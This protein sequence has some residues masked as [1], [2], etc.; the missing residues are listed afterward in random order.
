[1]TLPETKKLLVALLNKLINY[2]CVNNMAVELVVNGTTISHN[3]KFIAHYED[4]LDDIDAYSFY[5]S[6]IKN[7]NLILTEKDDGIFS[8]R[9]AISFS[10]DGDDDIKIKYTFR[11]LNYNI[12]SHEKPTTTINRIMEINNYYKQKNRKIVHLLCS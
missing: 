1:M 10:V 5:Y 3:S 2:S 6:E 7:F 4:L 11:S 12:I 9:S 8:Y